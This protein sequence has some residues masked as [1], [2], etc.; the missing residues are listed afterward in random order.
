MIKVLALSLLRWCTPLQKGL[1]RTLQGVDPKPISSTQKT[2]FQL[3]LHVP[4][5]YVFPQDITMTAPLSL[6]SYTRFYLS[7]WVWTGVDTH[8]N[9]S[10]SFHLEF[11]LYNYLV[12]QTSIPTWY[13]GSFTILVSVLWFVSTGLLFSTIY[14]IYKCFGSSI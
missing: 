6:T 7:W 11:L 10:I 8:L 9:P 2:S 3:P 4:L 14:V 5:S 12:D 1:A 13:S